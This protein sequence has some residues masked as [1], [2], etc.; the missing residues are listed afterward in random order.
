[1][2]VYFQ[3][4]VTR[5]QMS[6]K[7]Q[8]MSEPFSTVANLA[9]STGYGIKIQKPYNTEFSETKL[10]NYDHFLM[11]EANPHLQQRV[12]K[13]MDFVTKRVTNFVTNKYSEEQEDL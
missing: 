10:F 4:G 12:S 2:D 3:T 5:E 6:V 9:M 8:A 13:H 7:V 11:I 1:M